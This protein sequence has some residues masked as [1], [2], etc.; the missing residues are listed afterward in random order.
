VSALTSV[1]YGGVAGLVWAPY[2][3]RTARRLYT[4]VQRP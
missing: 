2:L 4:S 1:T 3:G